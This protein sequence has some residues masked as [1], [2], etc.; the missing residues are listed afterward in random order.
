[1]C[2]IYSHAFIHDEAV[3]CHFWEE[4][5]SLILCFLTSLI[6]VADCWVLIKL[7]NFITLFCWKQIHHV[8]THTLWFWHQPQWVLPSHGFWHHPWWVPS[9]PLALMP[10]GGSYPHLQLGFNLNSW[11]PTPTTCKGIHPVPI[12]VWIVPFSQFVKGQS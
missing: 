9:S 2:M 4:Q 5:S 10:P 8:L 6:S 11:V 3:L 12:Q 1:M 7:T